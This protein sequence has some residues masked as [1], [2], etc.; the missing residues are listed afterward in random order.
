MDLQQG[1]CLG[2]QVAAVA[3]E[4]PGLLGSWG[5]GEGPQHGTWHRMAESSGTA[6]LCPCQGTGRLCEGLQ[7]PTVVP[8]LANGK[9]Q[10]I[11]HPLTAYKDSETLKNSVGLFLERWGLH[12]GGRPVAVPG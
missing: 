6:K 10:W 11:W 12:G 4:Q 9:L 8:S 7:G 1:Q 2:Q 3:K 5:V